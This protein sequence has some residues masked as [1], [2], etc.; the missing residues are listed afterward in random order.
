VLA[1]LVALAALVRFVAWTRCAAIF[2]D[3]PAFLYLAEAILSGDWARVLQHP[4]H[5]GYPLLV[6]A[7]GWLG[8]AT[9]AHAL[10]APAVWVSIAAGAACV[11]LLYGFVAD[12]FGRAAGWT[13][14]ALLAIHPPAVFASADVQSDA[15]YTALFLAAAWAGW[16][17]LRSGRAAPAL[18]A[19]LLAG[20]AY[21][22]RPEGLGIALAVL[23]GG[24]WL[25]LRGRWARGRALVWC[26]A[27][28]LS[29]ALPLASYVAA[30]RAETGVWTLTQKKSLLVLAAF[31]AGGRAGS[32][33]P[34][35]AARPAGSLPGDRTPADGE[36][37]SAVRPIPGGGPLPGAEGAPPGW[38][39]RLAGA[40]GELY[41]ASVAALRFELLA[42]LAVGLAIARGRPGRRALLIGAS[43]ALY[44]AVLFALGASAG[45]VSRRHVLPP[46]L[47]GFGY[48][49][50]GLQASCAA[51][52][53]TLPR[54]P[55]GP[56]AA[57]IAGVGL[58]ALFFVPRDLAPRRVERLAV[59]E[60]AEWVADR[61]P[62]E[63][64]VAARRLR[65]AY[66]AQ[67]AYV[68]LP[69]GLA[70]PE[71]LLRY[72]RERR[73]G[74]V[75]I[76]AAHLRDHPQ[77]QAAARRAAGGLQRVHET[78]AAGH[79]AQVLALGASSVSGGPE[80]G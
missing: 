23:A 59:R 4:Y 34:P 48:V 51:L 32:T 26:A 35:P 73:V 49:A 74:W 46:L 11:A 76:D 28:G 57:G 10:E 54:L 79:R 6:A 66:Y 56:L 60:A 41:R 58:T 77:L 8:G 12:T 68:P 45:Y 24:L 33:R 47:L 55:H 70:S 69:L 80:G 39:A 15:A 3:G 5:P 65:V 2:D 53:R 42:F 36:P 13:A 40:A 44:A 17:A 22:V 25:L 63:R 29:M 78:Q 14:A 27:L 67:A 31:G 30:L 7:A 1:G 19:G 21:L 38:P 9:S 71:A 20:L 16:R 62:G 50:I 18:A 37:G 64:A 72:L 43:M 75:V 61:N 52:L